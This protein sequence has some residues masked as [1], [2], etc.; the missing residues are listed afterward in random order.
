MNPLGI[1]YPFKSQREQNEWDLRLGRD[2]AGLFDGP[3]FR[4]P[5]Y[6]QF[7]LDPYGGT[8]IPLSGFVDLTGLIDG[9][10]SFLGSLGLLREETLEPS[11]LKLGLGEV[12][13]RG[14]SA[15]KILF[16]DGIKSQKGRFFGWLPFQPVKGEIV[17]IESDAEFDRII[18]RGVFLLPQG[19]GKYKV[20]A[21]YDWEDTSNKITDSARRELCRRLDHLLRLEYEV[22]DQV[23][24]IRPAS[25]DRRPFI[26]FHPE[27]EQIGIFNGLG[28]KGVSLAPYFAERFSNCLEKGSELDSEVN[29]SR[30]FSLYFRQ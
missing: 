26:G 27:F 13:Y 3:V 11:D 16:C 21:T 22:V 8:V 20:G 10:R 15:N 9:Y 6:S 7:D 5:Q 18:N 12:V 19:R 17:T 29:I 14:V 25:K 24:G 4:E 28:T 2:A 30:Y 23:A 1:F